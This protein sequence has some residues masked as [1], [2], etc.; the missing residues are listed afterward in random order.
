MSENYDVILVLGGGLNANGGLDQDARDKL[1]Y[2]I[3]L[4]KQH[5]PKAIIVSGGYSYKL[6]VTPPNTEAQAMRD[7]LVGCGVTE[8]KIFTEEKSKDTLGNV[9]FSKIDLLRQHGWKDVLVVASVNHSLRRVDYLLTKILG[10][11]YNYEIIAQKTNDDNLNQ[12]RETK[13]LQLTKQLLDTVNDGDDQAVHEAM[14]QKHVAYSKNPE[15]TKE[16]IMQIF[17]EK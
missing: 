10:P 3:D 16:Q 1:D 12:D 9:Y 5:Q 13:S 4:A 6:S 15:L 2:V 17:D 7:Y 11:E 8:N 14:E